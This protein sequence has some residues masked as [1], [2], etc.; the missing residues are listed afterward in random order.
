MESVDLSMV[1]FLNIAKL[2]VVKP[3]SP[4]VPHI[5]LVPDFSVST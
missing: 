3:V 4:L 2:K 5:T 1:I